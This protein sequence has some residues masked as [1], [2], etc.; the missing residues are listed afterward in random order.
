MHNDKK[1]RRTQTDAIQ[2]RKNESDYQ[3]FH[4]APNWKIGMYE[5]DSLNFH[6]LD[7]CRIIAVNFYY[8][9]IDAS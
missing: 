6:R 2:S 1:S 7:K 3:E 4:L 8:Q 9:K 5:A